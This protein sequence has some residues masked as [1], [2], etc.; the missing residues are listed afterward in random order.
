MGIKEWFVPRRKIEVRITRIKKP[1]SDEIVVIQL[2]DATREDVF[3]FGRVMRTLKDNEGKF[4]VVNRAIEVFI[5]KK[6]EL[7]LK[8]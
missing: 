4:I 7:R 6:K 2:P 8:R 3:V 1:S 5:A